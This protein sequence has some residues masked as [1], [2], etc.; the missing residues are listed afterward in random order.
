MTPHHPVSYHSLKTMVLCGILVVLAC[1]LVTDTA[2]QTYLGNYTG[3]S[4]HGK[5]LTI[6]ADSSAVR[7]IFYAPDILRIDYLPAPA[8]HPDSSFVVVQDTT[9]VISTTLVETDSTIEISSPALRVVCR[10]FPLRLAYYDVSNVLLVAEPLAGGLA[11]SATSRSATFNMGA[12]EHFYGTGERGT[13]IDRR[14]QAF[15]SYNRQIGGYTSPLPTMNINIPFVAST[16]GYAIYFENTYAG[17]FQFGTDNPT[18]FSYTAQGGELSYYLIAAPAVAAQLDRYTWLTGR[19]PL[20]P[21]WALGFIQSRY[22]YHNES[23]AAAMI[24]SMRRKEIPCDAIVLDLYWFLHMG[25]LLWN[26]ASWPQPSTMMANFLARGFKTVVITE[27]Y[28]I[29]PST[30]FTMA[31]VYGYFA[32]NGSGQSYLLSNWWSC[33]CNAALLDLT[34]PLARQWWW[35]KHPSFFGNELAGIWTDLGEPERHP[36]DMVH[37]LGTTAKVHNIYNLLWAKTIFDGFQQMRPDQRIF[38]LTRSGYAGIQRYGVI[39]WSGD[40]GRSFGGLAVQPP[41]MLGM[42]MSG[43]AYHNS[44]IGGFCCGTTT[45]ELYIRWMQ[46]AT[47]CPITR[48]H[49]TGQATEPW[50]YGAVAESICTKFLRLRYQLLP[51]NYTLAHQNYLTGMPLARP[52]FFAE[53]GNSALANESSTYLW[54]D[55]FVVSPVLAAGQTSQ[56]VYLPPGIWLDYW[57][58]AVYKGGQAISVPTPLDRIPLFV[59]AGSIVPL[60]PVMNYSNER[61]LDTLF[62]EVYPLPNEQGTFTL[63]ED[64]GSTLAYQSGSFAQTIFSQ[65]VSQSADSLS[66][67]QILDLL[68]GTSDGNFTGKL[69]RRVYLA[70]IPTLTEPPSAVTV[71]DLPLE[72]RSSYGE[73]RGSGGC[74]FDSTTRRLYIQVAGSTDSSYHIT[75]H[76]F[77]T[78]TAVGVTP[79]PLKFHIYQNYPNPFNPVTIIRYALPHAGHVTLKVYNLLGE[80]V[81]TLVDEME[82]PGM[83]SVTFHAGSLPSGAYFYRLQSGEYTETKKLLLV[84]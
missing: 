73:L 76:N 7:F 10:K 4:S 66:G 64:D 22:G 9:A 57:T 68:I 12:D 31:D 37:Y 46:Y 81:K 19:Q 52:L 3:Y 83:K 25:D 38:N 26:T 45:P 54:G 60:Q 47:F 71:N 51:Y 69:P 13:P 15:D 77:R 14:G 42:G 74:Y 16:R 65:Q 53:P 29:Q 27:P 59:K 28:I 18:T 62:L 78:T 58:D 49:G 67:D 34:N 5:A 48:A 21:R 8:S 41:M 55:A 82:S 32:K 1:A 43:L 35:S 72:R 70:E 20:P 63:Y 6:Q 50:A 44:D 80:E 39:T 30:N 40:V 75:V 17:R 84:K 23:E 33:T 11:A 79:D 36:S 2:A 24:D 61:P 56:P